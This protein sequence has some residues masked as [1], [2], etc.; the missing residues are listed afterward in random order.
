MPP[1]VLKTLKEDVVF[2]PE[3]EAVAWRPRPQI[4]PNVIVHPRI[5]F[6]QPVLKRSHIPTAALAKA[7]SVE[8]NARFVAD[9]F[10]VPERHVREAVRF[11][12]HL[13]KAA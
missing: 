3:G 12:E 1:V 4:A 10:E 13:R 8:G 11:E 2:D 5:S 7:V 6:G 9:V